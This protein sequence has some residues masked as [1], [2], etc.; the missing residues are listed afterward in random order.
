MGLGTGREAKD[1]GIS[2][3]RGARRTSPLPE[4]EGCVRGER[5]VFIFNYS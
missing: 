5:D 2:E 3:R 4:G 1:V